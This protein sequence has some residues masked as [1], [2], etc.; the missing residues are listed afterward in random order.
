MA[1]TN[2]VTG[3]QLCRSG[4]REV[5]RATRSA[6]AARDQTEHNGDL[7]P[8]DAYTIEADGNVTRVLDETTPIHG[9]VEA[10][11]LKTK[12]GPVSY[13]MLPADVAG[14]VIGIE[15]PDCEFEVQLSGATG[16]IATST[17]QPANVLDAAPDTTLHRSRQSLDDTTIGTGVQVN[18]LRLVD[19]PGNAIGQYAKVACRLIQTL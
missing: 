14:E 15:D 7:A 5:K 6:D 16:F 4:G 8:G 3:F 13:A 1:N 19:R 12:D 2:V 18:V 17:G 10:I 9:I 11:V